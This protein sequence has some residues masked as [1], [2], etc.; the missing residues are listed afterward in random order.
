MESQT[1][2][3]TI[4]AMFYRQAERFGERPMMLI[5]GGGAYR[6]LSWRAV[7]DDVESLAGWLLQRG[8]APGDRVAIFV[9][10]RPEWG[11]ADLAA[12]SVGAWGV[13]IYPTLKAHDVGLI[14]EDCRPAA[15]IASGADRLATL[16]SA[17]ARLE[18]PPAM[19]ALDAPGVDDRGVHAWPQALESGRRALEAVRPELERRRAAL[20]PADT[21]T[22]I[23]TSGT[24]GIPKGVMLSHRNFLSNAAASA[25][26]VP[27]GP[28]DVHL[29]FLP[30][31]HVFERMAGWYLMMSVGARIAFAES[32][33]TVPQN[34]A[35]VRPSVMLGVPR[36]FEKLYARVQERLGAMPARKRRL[37][38]W[39]LGVGRRH[40]EARFAGR[41][42]GPGL[43]LAR[44]A[45]DRLV[46]RTFRRRLGGRLRFFVSGSAP[47]S[48]EIGE[49]FFWIGVTILEGYGLTETS[50]VIAVNRLERPRF[51]TVGPPLPGVEVRIAE[52]GEILTR[53][54][55]VMQGYYG[56]PADTA[57]VIRDGWLHTGDVGE[58]N[59][60]GV[61]RITDRKKDL[62]KTAGGKFV[63]PQRLENLFVMD[64]YVSQAFV[65]GDTRP[66]CVALIV[67]QAEALREHARA[68]GLPDGSLAELVSRPDIQAWYWERVQAAQRDLAGFEQVKKIALLDAEFS[69]DSGELTPTLKTKRRCVAERYQVLLDSL[70]A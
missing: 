53:G 45:A 68:Q 70:Y 61:L 48:R 51:G 28:E 11:I 23:Y 9:E 69:L 56:R 5:K 57:E 33:D 16:V 26:V 44:A 30:L 62:I 3:G 65:Y 2:D 20:R 12:Q 10:N 39:A 63:A 58:L 37:V 1:A 27:I 36:F 60:E 14:L 21:A 4:P 31:S 13:P 64:P 40:A 49:F 8:V 29:S 41:R 19:I 32:M 34:M 25:S 17:A 54:P 22:L 35:E 59:A 47:L 15:A 46:F 50:P 7:R 6:P 18:R 42:P 43:A 55:H 38:E 52:D 66:F 24:T 67:P